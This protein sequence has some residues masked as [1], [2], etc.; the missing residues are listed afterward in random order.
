M[1]LWNDPNRIAAYPND[2]RHNQAAQCNV[3]RH[4]VVYHGR[5][6]LEYTDRKFFGAGINLALRSKPIL[7]PSVMPLLRNAA[8]QPPD[9]RAQN[10]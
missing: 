6:G 4:I 1:G 10:N 8:N 5:I 7:N 2:L 9:D 3:L